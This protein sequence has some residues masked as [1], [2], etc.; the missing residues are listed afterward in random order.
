MSKNRSVQRL[1]GLLRASVDGPRNEYHVGLLEFET[2]WAGQG[3]IGMYLPV[4]AASEDGVFFS[5]WYLPA[6]PGR[7]RMFVPN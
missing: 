2:G 1:G 4:H 3:P 7:I 6:G 5:L